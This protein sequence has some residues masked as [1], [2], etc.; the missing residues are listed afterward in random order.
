MLLNF[1][2]SLFQAVEASLRGSVVCISISHQSLSNTS[3][4]I[5]KSVRFGKAGV[6]EHGQ[7][8]RNSLLFSQEVLR[9]SRPPHK[10]KAARKQSE[11]E[12][13]SLRMFQES[14][15]PSIILRGARKSQTRRAA[16]N[17]SESEFSTCN[18][19]VAQCKQERLSALPQE[20]KTKAMANLFKG[21]CF[22]ESYLATVFTCLKQVKLPS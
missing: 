1:I 8:I 21:S 9:V 7:R 5:T 18:A 13:G 20:V 17:H 14:L 6:L 2:L 3:G 16:R 11:P 22:R 4:S 15:P 19:S 12:L 10:R